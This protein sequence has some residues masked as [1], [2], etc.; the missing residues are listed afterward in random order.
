MTTAHSG[1]V[2]RRA[3]QLPEARRAGAE[4]A[5]LQAGRDADGV[6][7]L[8]YAAHYRSLVRL[9]DLLVGDLAAAEEVVQ[10]SF[11]AMHGHWRRLRY[12][13]A[14]SY[15]RKSVINRSRCVQSRVVVDRHAQPQPPD[16]PSAEQDAEAP[17]QRSAVVAALGSLPPRQR[18]AVVLQYYGDWSEA[19][20]AAA[21]GISKSAVKRHTAL[22][23]SALRAMLER[24][25]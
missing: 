24:R 25:E 16:A 8:L 11:V 5:S 2:A 9:A 17:L 13:A 23:R 10:E 18:E 7:T 1:D 14:L 6:L 3:V 20:V 21:M 15:L 22:A 12:R 19:Q 4:L